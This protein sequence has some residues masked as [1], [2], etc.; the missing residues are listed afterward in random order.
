MEVPLRR[1]LLTGRLAVMAD[2]PANSSPWYDLDAY[3]A[4][5]RL[6]ALALSPD[7]TRVMVSLAQPDPTGTPYQSAWWALDP[8]GASPARRMTRSSEG[9]SFGSF[10]PDGS[11]LFGS[12]RPVPKG[13]EPAAEDASALWLLPATGGEAYPLVQRPGGYSG[14]IASAT[15]PTV[16]AKTPSHAGVADDEEDAAKRKARSKAKVSAILHE[17]FPVRFWD[18]D[19]GPVNDRI[20]RLD[21]TSSGGEVSASVRGL[22]GDLGA[23]LAQTSW[24]LSAD[25]SRL[26]T[27]WQVQRSRSEVSGTVVSIDPATGERTTL[28]ADPA[29]EFFAPV[30]SADATL[31]ACV[32]SYQSSPERA[33]D[34]KL[35]LIDSSGGRVL[36]ASWD[37]WGE[38]IAFSP[39][40]AT[41]YVSA[42]EDGDHPIF[43][44]DLATEQV[45]RLTGAGAFTSV[46]LST[47][48]KTLYAIRSSYSDPGSV[49]AIDAATGNLRELRSPVS[50][51]E[52]PGRVERVETRAADGTRVPG[53]L[54]LP[55]G[56]SASDP[57]PLALWIHGGPLGSWNAWSWRW[58]PWLLASRGWA[59]LLPDPALSTGYGLDYIQRG[60]G[61][62]G[63]EP[64]TDLMALTDA[65]VAR[66]D[67]DAERT[68]AMGGS[69]GGY[70]ANWVAGHTDRFR[71]IVTHASLW[72][73]ESF[74]DTTDAAWY[75]SREMSPEMRS[76]YSPHL[77]ASQIRT[78][79][80]VIHGDKDYRVPI[81][82]GLALWWALASHW[83]GDEA[84]FGH[85]FLYFPDE[86][87][88]ILTPQ[89]AKVWYQTVC[90]FIDASIGAG[91]FVRPE[92][93]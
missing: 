42:D 4:L 62:W 1:G 90:S 71:A 57:A 22:G 47:D 13:A 45:R 37:R 66:P 49:V 81:G 14:L 74:G 93:L 38:P 72:N 59:V 32:R 30:V 60:W 84:G 51:P 5:P 36:A 27:G 20:A 2:T 11:F 82:E 33:V 69:F 75:W 61:H 24:A 6:G 29:D 88:W 86:N 41:L 21:L 73:L 56:A 3:I 52:L 9:E 80:L 63:R 23:A 67:I 44:V 53:Y 26:V 58:C 54:V 15:S 46:T 77:S 79:M 68:V 28:A 16:F 34:Q 39:D 10:L 25:G 89:H 83:D 64:F 31:V 70:M 12:K 8:S 43:A 50:Y 85:K 92:L 48:G 19:L 17:T 65:A 18:H 91:E 78:P 40:N 87:H 7:G 76:A 55:E 35:W